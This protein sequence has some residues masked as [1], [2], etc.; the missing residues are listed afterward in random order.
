M[1]FSC[2]MNYFNNDCFLIVSWIISIMF[3]YI[4]S[5]INYVILLTETRWRVLNKWPSWMIFWRKPTPFMPPM[6]FKRVFRHLCKLLRLFRSST[7]WWR[8]ILVWVFSIFKCVN[9]RL[10]RIFLNSLL[11]YLMIY[12]PR[13]N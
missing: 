8:F 7:L 5:V 10:P 11:I 12:L 3:V 1:L 6:P 2:I 9:I 4:K 13:R